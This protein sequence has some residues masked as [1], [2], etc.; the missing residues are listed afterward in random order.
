[1]NKKTKILIIDDNM[2][3]V[4]LAQEF[5][6]RDK[7]ICDIDSVLSGNDALDYLGG[8]GRF[9]GISPPDIILL[10]LNM[11]DYDGKDLLVM[12]R[13]I[14]AAKDIPIIIYSGSESPK[15]FSETRALGAIHYLVKPI[16]LQKMQDMVT[17]V[18]PFQINMADD[19][20]YHL[21]R[22]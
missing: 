21:C 3:E 19:G 1:M 2:A 18:P 13:K 10:D 22:A 15:D 4:I 6:R 9:E 17:Y 14:D 12:I 16:S 11:P 20:T 5:C 7:I 8:V